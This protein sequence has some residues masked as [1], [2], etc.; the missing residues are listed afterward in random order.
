MKAVFEQIFDG[1]DSVFG[2]IFGPSQDA[3]DE[4]RKLVR[5]R[6]WRTIRF[7]LTQSQID[8]LQSGDHVVFKVGDENFIITRGD[9]K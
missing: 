2:R 3:M 1:P 4:A 9:G 8:R 7:K 6:K 5:K